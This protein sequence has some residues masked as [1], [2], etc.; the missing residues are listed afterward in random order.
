[1]LTLF[2]LET[3]KSNGVKFIQGRASA[4]TFDTGRVTQINVICQDETT[5]TL[6]CD[7][8]VIAAGPWTVPLS[9]SLL[10]TPIPVTA[11]AGHSI[12]V[13]PAT[14]TS[15]DCL[16]MTLN[17]QNVSYHTEILPRS[18]GEIYISGIND[19]LPLPPTPDAA[20][21]QKS[22][23][24]KLREIADEV[25]AEYTI[26]KEQLCFRPMTESGNPFISPIS[27]AKGVYVGAGH[28]YFGLILGP[29]TG[30][31]LSEMILGEELSVD[32]SGLSL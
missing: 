19:N 29:G 14:S 17:C 12:L 30:K 18:S 26:E 3:A 28:S 13:R 16:F 4:L 23:I 9:K 10:L 1:L 21:P 2:L 8:V 27:G 32:V 11:Y 5:L 20:T 6:P 22:E 25:F 7:N 24:D 15:A 31:V